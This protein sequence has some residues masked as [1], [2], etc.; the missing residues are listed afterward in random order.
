MTTKKDAQ[1]DVERMR[2]RFDDARK[3]WD[4][5]K[6]E[7][8][9]SH[10]AEMV[11]AW[12]DLALAEDETGLAPFVILRGTLAGWLRYGKHGGNTYTPWELVTEWAR[13][14]KE[15]GPMRA[16]WAA[17]DDDGVGALV[18][19]L[20][21]TL[22]ARATEMG[23]PKSGAKR[24]AFEEV[25]ANDLTLAA[26]TKDAVQ[27]MAPAPVEEYAKPYPFQRWRFVEGDVGKPSRL[28]WSRDVFQFGHVN[29]LVDHLARAE[30]GVATLA[31]VG[32]ESPT[33]FWAFGFKHAGSVTVLAEADPPSGTRLGVNEEHQVRDAYTWHQRTWFPH[34]WYNENTRSST[35][36]ADAPGNRKR[37]AGEPSETRLVP[38]DKPEPIGK[39]G[40]LPPHALAWFTLL[41]PMMQAKVADAHE[42]L[43]L[44][45]TGEMVTLPHVAGET[46]TALV[47]AG[48]VRTVPTA[49]VRLEDVLDAEKAKAFV[50][51]GAKGTHR[52]MTER[53]VPM[54]DAETVDA[55]LNAA[56]PRDVAR[57]QRL[58]DAHW[59]YPMHK[60]SEGHVDRPRHAYYHL[61]WMDPS[62]VGTLEEALAE[63]FRVARHNL[64]VAVQQ[65]ADHEFRT[66]KVQTHAWLR[67]RADARREAILDKLASGEWNLVYRKYPDE[68]RVRNAVDLLRAW[69]RVEQLPDFESHYGRWRDALPA[70]TFGAKGEV[71]GRSA[72]TWL[73]CES[74]KRANVAARVNVDNVAALAEVLD[75][76][77]DALPPGLHAWYADKPSVPNTG[78]HEVDAEDVVLTNPWSEWRLDV[79]A[80]WHEP[81]LNARRAKQGLPPLEGKRH[82]TPTKAE[83]A[84]EARRAAKA[85]GEASEAEG[86]E[87]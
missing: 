49:R 84:R 62:F 44:R 46:K 36:G 85:K 22:L 83:A 8:W 29:S 67:E 40:D 63:R 79:V 52:W 30:D 11:D 33:A 75:V 6:D 16:A 59:P 72:T 87:G 65:L 17:L 55:L 20:R 51:Y 80:F 15:L 53:Y 21:E 4:K 86:D 58:L 78:F 50:E 19:S 24:E 13:V 35:R 71:P 60:W 25:L 28:K 68:P 45:V 57:A 54:L 10:D 70:L 7:N 73:C 3:K 76:A 41:T 61:K 66:T 18:A 47:L 77:M 32:R 31:L 34:A 74:G 56:T 38:A 81:A 82:G 48:D 14:N 64:M 39:V 5:V 9:N 2:A 37:A 27:A 43:P 1:T 42:K 23:L 12:L 26:L 69:N